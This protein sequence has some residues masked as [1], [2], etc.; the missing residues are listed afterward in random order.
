VYE[1][2]LSQ[3]AWWTD[4]RAEIRRA[5]L[6][7]DETITAPDAVTFDEDNRRMQARLDLFG[8][9]PVRDAY[10]HAALAGKEYFIAVLQYRDFQRTN[11]EALAAGTHPGQVD[12]PGLV[13]ARNRMRSA[14][15]AAGHLEKKLISVAHAAISRIP[16]Y[17]RRRR[18]A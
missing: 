9:P 2:A 10:E 8:E 12:Q 6:G 7:D 15:S 5:L 11:R 17:G 4:L 16:K 13:D 1:Y 3:V 18:R 14:D